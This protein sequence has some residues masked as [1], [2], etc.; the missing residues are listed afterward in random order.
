[1]CQHTNESAA[2]ARKTPAAGDNI[3]LVPSFLNCT[4]KYRLPF[5]HPAAGTGMKPS[6]SGKSSEILRELY[7]ISAGLGAILELTNR[8]FS[9][10]GRGRSSSPRPSGGR[11]WDANHFRQPNVG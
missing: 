3:L 8:N 6:E 4:V 9:R 10:A 11:T 5:G 7:D 1:M 2:P